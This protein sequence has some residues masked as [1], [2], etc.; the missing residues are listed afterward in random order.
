MTATS[1]VLA[2]IIARATDIAIPGD[3]Y[4]GDAVLRAVD[5][6]GIVLTAREY[7]HATCATMATVASMRRGTR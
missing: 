7:R 6:R 5:E 3:I 4:P 2:A 1:E